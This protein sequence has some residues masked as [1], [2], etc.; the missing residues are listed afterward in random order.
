[1]SAVVKKKSEEERASFLY[2]FDESLED[3]REEEDSK[4]IPL[5]GARGAEEMILSEEEV[6]R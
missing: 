5:L 3:E 4:W 1:M 2:S 6:R